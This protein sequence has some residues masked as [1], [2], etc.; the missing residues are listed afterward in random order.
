M[1][2]TRLHISG[3][4]PSIS[5]RD[6]TQRFSTFGEVRGVDGVGKVDGLGQPRK[7]AYVTLETT[8]P[9]LSRCMNL[10]SGATWKGA[11]LRIGEAKPDYRARHEL[12]INPLPRAPRPKLD[13]AALK[14]ARLKRRLKARRLMRGTQGKEAKDMSVVTLDNVSTHKGWR[15]TP[16]DHLVRPLRMRPLHPIPLPPKRQSGKSKSKLK[17]T[18]IVKKKEKRKFDL[19]RARCTVIDPARYGAV[20]LKA[21]GGILGMD[22]LVGGVGGVEV[23]SD[24][25][26]ERDEEM[27]EVESTLSSGDTD[28]HNGALPQE[29][30]ASFEIAAPPVTVIRPSTPPPIQRTPS[31]PLPPVL[32]PKLP[33]ISRA[34]DPFL[35]LTKEK[36]DVLALLGGMFSKDEEWG[37]RES[38]SGDEEAPVAHASGAAVEEEVGYEVVP[39]DGKV[40]EKEQEDEGKQ[41]EKEIGEIAE[42]SRLV[43]QAEEEDEDESTNDDD[44]NDQPSVP[45]TQDQVQHTTLKDMFKPQEESGGFSLGLDID[46]DP[47]AESFLPSSLIATAR[48]PSP[49]TQ[50]TSAIPTQTQAQGHAIQYTPDPHAIMFFPTFSDSSS[51]RDVFGVIREKGWEWA[52]PGTSDEIRAK[53]DAQKVELTREYTKRYREAVKRR[54]RGGTGKGEDV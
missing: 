10:L 53:W 11:K 30:I 8:Q 1:Q 28:D 36:A 40:D 31:S 2:T 17:K 44:N 50:A 47:D 9:K 33:A 5:E 39:K 27:A 7:F 37:G 13:A 41:S 6:L 20:H 43:V 15:R 14:R 32:V 23:G 3:L 4:T 51:K 16:L 19:T 25:R 22:L 42:E 49:P 18:A 24:E 26:G 46:L 54:R 52:H 48:S 29:P 38:V 12:E 34:D 21:G 35:S 45:V